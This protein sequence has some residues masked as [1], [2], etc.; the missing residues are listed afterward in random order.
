MSSRQTRSKAAK[1]RD[2]Q[3]PSDD[4]VVMNGNGNGVAL[5]TPE[6]SDDATRE[7]IFLFWPNIIGKPK[8]G[9]AFHAMR[10]ILFPLSQVG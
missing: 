8:T 4:E 9:N 6:V 3:S 7:N 5:Q 1:A 2:A 10:C